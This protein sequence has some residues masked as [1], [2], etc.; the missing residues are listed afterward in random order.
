MKKYFTVF[1]G[2]NLS[3]KVIFSSPRSTSTVSLPVVKLSSF[4]SST[5]IISYSSGAAQVAQRSGHKRAVNE[6]E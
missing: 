5:R 2:A 6:P 3:Q 1:A 4:A